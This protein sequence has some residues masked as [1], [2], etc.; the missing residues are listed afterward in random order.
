MSRTILGLEIRSEAISAALVGTSLKGNRLEGLAY[1]PFGAEEDLSQ[2]VNA[3]LKTLADSVDLEGAVCVTSL[4]ANMASYRSLQ[5]PFKDH[6][7]I[8]Q[9]LPYELESSLPTPISELSHDFTIISSGDDTRVLAATVEKQ[10]LQALLQIL[11]AAKLEP[12]IVT[13]GGLPTAHCLAQATAVPADCLLLEIGPT[14][15]TLFVIAERLISQLRAFAIRGS[16]QERIKHL[17]DNIQHTVSAFQEDL[18]REYKPELIL[19]TGM[20]LQGFSPEEALSTHFDV[21]VRPANILTD[22]EVDMALD[23]TMNWHPHVGNQA[24]A[25]A[26]AEIQHFKMLNF[27]RRT[28]ALRKYWEKHKSAFTR[29]GILAGIVALLAA[30]SIL[31]EIDALEK[32]NQKLE[33]AINSV[34]RETFPEVTRIVDPARQME[35]KIKDLRKTFVL[36]DNA[37]SSVLTIDILNEISKSIPQ[38]TDVELDRIVVAADNVQVSGDTDTFNAVDDIK[39]RLEASIFKTVTISAANMDRKT[40]RVKFKLRIDL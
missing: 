35:E 21:T 1:V 20:G 6:K 40:Q 18:G 24:V 15:A 26:L 31:F 17:I 14:E 34:F 23:S 37:T 2:K 30:F 16:E 38:E 22:T 27:H 33:S 4:P 28:F 8:R 25:L 12:E 3:A 7:K 13:V 19:T 32:Q 36:S 9:V 39:T 29:T 11:A 10:E 5:L